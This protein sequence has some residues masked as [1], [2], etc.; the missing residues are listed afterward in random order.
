MSGLLPSWSAVVVNVDGGEILFAAL[1]S[2][3]AQTEPPGEIVVIDNGSRNEERIEM[4]RR[5]PGVRIVALGKN[6]GFAEGA[7]RGI[8]AT[9]AP[10][11]ALINND[12]VLDFD[13][14]ERLLE[15]VVEGE[16]ERDIEEGRGHVLMQIGSRRLAAL[17]GAVLT[18]DGSFVDT[19]GIRFDE[20]LSAIPHAAGVE[21]GRVAGW[22]PFRIHGP[23]ATAALYRREALKE[24]AGSSTVFPKEFFAYYEDVDLVLR[25]SR[26]GWASLSVPRAKARHRGSMTGDRDPIQR[27]RWIARNRAWTLARNLDLKLLKKVGELG[28][29]SRRS[30]FTALGEAGL[31]GLRG[32]LT[33]LREGS[34]VPPPPD[35]IDAPKLRPDQLREE[36]LGLDTESH[37]S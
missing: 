10:W 37:R 23:S 29:G 1:E 12:V 36:A 21:A 13:W 17:Q 18:G 19:L 30:I 16:R 5:Y 8:A 22:H 14:G 7:N 34:E 9:S 11:I 35:P 27:R 24:A 20:T 32:A 33:G 4:A 28:R 6:L 3:L 15:Q 26:L 25:L 31:A 2:I